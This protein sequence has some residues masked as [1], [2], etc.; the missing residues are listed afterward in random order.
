[1]RR[2]NTPVPRNH[3]PECG[4]P[5]TPGAAQGLCA[6]CLIAGAAAPTEHIAPRS[7]PPALEQ[8]AAAF[9]HLEILELIGHGGMGAVFKVRQPKL[10]RFAALKLLPQSLAADP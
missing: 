8:V 9:P 3:C 1:M 10:D 4:A 5:L 6:R 7:T 2:M